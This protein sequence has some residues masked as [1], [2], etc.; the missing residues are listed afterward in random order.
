MVISSKNSFA[1]NTGSTSLSDLLIVSAPLH[2]NQGGKDCL[3]ANES[4]RYLRNYDHRILVL[5]FS[6]IMLIYCEYDL[7]FAYSVNE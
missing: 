4:S 7:K 6:G 1:S 3:S 2:H 5:L